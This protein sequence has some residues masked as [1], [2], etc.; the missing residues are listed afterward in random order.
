MK[1]IGTYLPSLI[2][3]ILLVL[4]MICSVGILIVDININ[5][6]QTI[7]LT[8]KKDIAAKTSRQLE[9]EFKEISGATGIPAEIYTKSLTEDYIQSLINIYINEGYSSL[10]SGGK[11]NIDIPK[12]KEM[13]A[14]V[15]EFFNNMAEQ[16]GYEKNDDFYEKLNNTKQNA[17]KLIGE[18]CDVYKFT[19]LEKHGVLGPVS[20]VYKIR[21]LITFVSTGGLALLILALIFVNR[22]EKKNVLYWTGISAAIAGA[23]GMIPSIYLISTKYFNAFSIKQPQIFAAYTGGMFKLTEAFMAASISVCAAGIAMIVLYVVIGCHRTSS[24]SKEKL[25]EINKKNI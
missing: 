12:N 11:M 8:E 5:G 20:K 25:P 17:Y 7:T 22:K 21:P 4:F 16:T 3:S 23:I 9:H 1:K 6:S 10:K 15:E 2:I 13:E 14:D 18:A 24:E 19:S